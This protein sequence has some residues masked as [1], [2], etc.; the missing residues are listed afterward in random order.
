MSDL[1]TAPTPL[2]VA[3]FKEAKRAT[4]DRLGPANPVPK[5][6]DIHDQFVAAFTVSGVTPNIVELA[7]AQELSDVR[8]RLDALGFRDLDDAGALAFSDHV[9]LDRPGLI[10]SSAANPANAVK[11]DVPLPPGMQS[12]TVPGWPIKESVIIAAEVDLRDKTLTIDARYVSSLI[13]IATRKLKASTGAKITYVPLASSA[14]A[15]PGFDGSPS[16]S[17]PNYA[18]DERPG[19]DAPEPSANGGDGVQGGAGNS[20][21]DGS[22]APDVTITTLDLDAMPDIILPGQKGGKGGTGG[23]GGDGGRGQRGRDCLSTWVDCRKGPGRG[24]NG[25]RGG[26][27]GQGGRGGKGGQGGAVTVLAPEDQLAAMI[28][29]RRFVIDNAGGEGGDPGVQGDPGDG[30]A[31]GLPGYAY[32]RCGNR[33]DRVGANGLPGQKTGDLGRGPSGSAGDIGYLTVTAAGIASLLKEPWIIG[34]DHTQVYPGDSIVLGGTNFTAE[35]R[36]CLVAQGSSNSVEVP[37]AFNSNTQITLVVPESTGSGRFTIK[38][39]G[40]GGLESNSVPVA[41]VPELTG[42]LVGGQAVTKIWAG[43]SVTLSGRGFVSGEVVTCDGKALPSVLGSI[44]ALTLTVPSVIGEDP[45][46]NSTFCVTSLEG[47]RSNELSILRL[48][49]VDNGLRARINGF[50][51]KNFEHGQNIGLGTYAKTFGTT[52]V[53]AEWLLDPL[54]SGAYFAFYEYYLSGRWP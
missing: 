41:V 31:G 15:G 20:G 24:G 53:A 19:C 13:I 10:L 9:T 3:D 12:Y 18:V 4:R 42:I 14:I 29:A 11:R 21:P 30:G 45:G 39:I 37:T 17:Q 16:P 54:L 22:D 38:L 33:P 34:A 46:G 49:S 2:T 35:L 44:R 43:Q 25:G 52:E 28:T 36:A 5:F 6:T 32:S 8:S 26:D 1:L 48:P 51:F 23:R 50:A 40:R 7:T 47:F 27:G